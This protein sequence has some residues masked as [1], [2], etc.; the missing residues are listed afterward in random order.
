M[1]PVA[2]QDW[3][4]EPA[5]LSFAA[6]PGLFAPK[7][8]FAR[9]PLVLQAKSDRILLHRALTGAP[10]LPLACRSDHSFEQEL[11]DA[12]AHFRLGAF[13]LSLLHPRFLATE[14]SSDRPSVS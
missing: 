11:Q 10:L 7:I 14:A 2:R 9:Q 4:E 5:L 3:E 12:H 1:E 6:F 8:L 13:R